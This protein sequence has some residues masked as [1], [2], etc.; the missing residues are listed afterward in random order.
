MHKV[1][2]YEPRILETLYFAGGCF[3]GVEAYFA[4]MLG[5]IATEVGFIDISSRP[6]ATVKSPTYVDIKNGG[7]KYVEAVKVDYDKDWVAAKTLVTR[8]FDIIDPT[9]LDK[10]GNDIGFQYNTGV[11]Y[12]PQSSETKTIVDQ[13]NEIKHQFIDIKKAFYTVLK[14]LTFFYLAD[15]SHQDYL[16]KNPNGYCHIN[17]DTLHTAW[18]LIDPNVYNQK[19][20]S[21]LTSIQYNVTQNSA[22]EKPFTGEYDVTF[23][24]GIYVDIVSG[25]PLFLSTK[26]FNSGCGWPSFSEPIEKIAVNELPDDSILGRHRTE[27]RSS[28][29]NSHLGHVFNDAP[30]VDTGLR[31]CINSAALQFIPFSEMQS[32]GYGYLT[33]LLNTDE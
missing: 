24:K 23:K 7:T 18:A 1:L 9:Q 11:F 22:T 19:S 6:V 3:W 5:V 32:R 31:Y 13:F 33:N 30:Q 10:Q 4:N 21:S 12:E 25:E 8:F 29:A 17:Y 28:N 16:S 20:I 27:V 2:D 26:K 15:E 14:P